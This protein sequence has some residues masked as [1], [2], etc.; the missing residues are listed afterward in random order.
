MIKKC[1]A[2][3]AP[4]DGEG[5]PGF[6]A[7]CESCS[8]FLHSC[9]NCRLHDP[10]AHN[11]CLSS[12]TEYVADREGPNWCDEFDFKTTG[13]EPKAPGEGKD[14]WDRLFNGGDS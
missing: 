9:K 1:H 8:A 7:V 3:G 2:C 12:T 11:E 10:T 13:K 4:W 5:T 6:K 14:A